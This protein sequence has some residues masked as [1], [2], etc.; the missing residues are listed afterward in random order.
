MN[1]DEDKAGAPARAF[2]FNKD[3]KPLRVLSTSL[4]IALLANAFIGGGLIGEASA[5]PGTAAAGAGEPKLVEWSTEAVKAFYDPSVDWNIPLPE[6]GQ[7]ATE[8]EDDQ[9][10]GAS[11]GGTGA[12]T[13]GGTTVIQH[14]AFGWDDLL[15]YHLIFN[16]GSAYSSASWY[17]NHKAYDTRTG[18]A[19]KPRTYSADTF[20]NKPVVGSAVRPRTTDTTGS[21]TRRS[22]SSSKGGIGGNSSG[23]SSSSSGKSSFGGFGG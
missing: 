17:S 2:L 11:S 1:R 16:R 10:S 15:L 22:T 20:Q 6:A 8:E 19:Y 13:G 9:G 5:E 7:P 21:V 4:G 12:S 18:T 14:S 23:F 3:G